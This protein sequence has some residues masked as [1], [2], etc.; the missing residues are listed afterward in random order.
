MSYEVPKY[1]V[2][3]ILLQVAFSDNGGAT[4][5]KPGCWRGSCPCQC[6]DWGILHQPTVHPAA[7]VAPPALQTDLSST[8]YIENN[9]ASC[10]ER[11]IAY[12]QYSFF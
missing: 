11:L 2:F 5:A 8:E 12:L 6:H 4:A 7:A 3:N 1:Q 10:S 9:S